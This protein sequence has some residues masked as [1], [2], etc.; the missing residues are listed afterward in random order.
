MVDIWHTWQACV[1]SRA[2][3]ICSA[4]SFS[5]RLL[6]ALV[7]VHLHDKMK[8][9]VHPVVQRVTRIQLC[10]K[11]RRT[12]RLQLLFNLLVEVCIALERLSAVNRPGEYIER[13]YWIVSCLALFFFVYFSPNLVLHNKITCRETTGLFSSLQYIRD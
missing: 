3:Q 9:S 6:F 10:S 11:A 4:H 2:W 7:L 13:V 12:L 5:L 8:H 1:Y